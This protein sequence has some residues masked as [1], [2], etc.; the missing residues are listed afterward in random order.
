[1]ETT[2]APIDWQAALAVHDRWLRTV[3][4]ARVQE[5][6]AVDDVMQEVALAAVRQAAPLADV[7]KLAPWLYQLAVRQS[8][9]YRRKCGRGRR[10][11]AG[12][13]ERTR[14]AQVTERSHPLAWLLAGERQALVRR[15]LQ[16]LPARDAQILLLK[17]TEDWNYHQIAG[18]LGCSHSAVET[19]LHR[20]RQRLRTALLQL[21]S[22]IMT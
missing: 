6:Q 15:A 8:L 5:P 1:M 14:E 19:R 2:L 22:E 7:A 18:H 13:F 9:L 21:N 20:A 10:L 3:V 16:V 17:Y 12:V 11:L 4:L